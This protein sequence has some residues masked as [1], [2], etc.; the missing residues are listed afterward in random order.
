MK[1]SNGTYFTVGPHKATRAG[2]DVAVFKELAI[3]TIQARTTPTVINCRE[4][5]NKIE[6]NCVTLLEISIYWQNS[7]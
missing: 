2:A 4:K 5:R 6:N 1:G 7:S 3:S